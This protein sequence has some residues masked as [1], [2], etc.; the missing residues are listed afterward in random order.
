MFIRRPSNQGYDGMDFFKIKF[1]INFLIKM[2]YK[3][4][5]TQTKYKKKTEKFEKKMVIL[6]A[7]LISFFSLKFFL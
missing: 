4:K 5:D 1:Q 6:N 7:F 2:I 3:C